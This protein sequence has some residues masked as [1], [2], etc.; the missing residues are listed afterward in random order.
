M[1]VIFVPLTLALEF[2]P[3]Q[4]EIYLRPDVRR[5][6]GNYPYELLDEVL[7]VAILYQKE[8][9]DLEKFVKEN[10]KSPCMVRTVNPGRNTMVQIFSDKSSIEKFMPLDQQIRDPRWAPGVY[11]LIE[12]YGNKL[13]QAEKFIRRD[14]DQVVTEDLLVRQQCQ[15]KGAMVYQDRK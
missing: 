12:F 14:G 2:E 5:F 10:F 15:D 11:G 8:L 13:I 4:L 1:T 7:P 9:P 3:F 6:F